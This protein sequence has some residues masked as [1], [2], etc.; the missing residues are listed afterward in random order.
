MCLYLLSVR[1]W[2]ILIGNQ[3]SVI[4]LLA[5]GSR[6]MADPLFLIDL[7]AFCSISTVS[8]LQPLVLIALV[9]VAASYNMGCSNVASRRH[10]NYVQFMFLACI[11][12]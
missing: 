4:I 12:V 10:Y 3:L 8:C 6:H 2:L 5:Q 11:S 1:N 9:C 7:L